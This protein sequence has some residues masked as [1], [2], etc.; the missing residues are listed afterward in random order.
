MLS[1]NTHEIA[2]YYKITLHNDFILKR[3]WKNYIRIIELY[4]ILESTI[5]L[6]ITT[7]NTKL[8]HEIKSIWRV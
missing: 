6:D 8:I 3:F 2:V 1:K 4:A 5:I 7:I